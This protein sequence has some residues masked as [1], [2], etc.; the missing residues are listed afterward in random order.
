[1]KA[2]TKSGQKSFLF[3]RKCVYQRER[4]WKVKQPQTL[5]FTEKPWICGCCLIVQLMGL[6]PTPK[7]MDMNLNHARMPIPPQLQKQCSYIITSSAIFVNNYFQ[8]FLTLISPHIFVFTFY[9][10]IIPTHSH[11]LH[12]SPHI[13]N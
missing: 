4:K 10:A 13:L 7:Y 5:D 11:L 2:G 6:E 8:T 12:L 1:M 3:L 9:S